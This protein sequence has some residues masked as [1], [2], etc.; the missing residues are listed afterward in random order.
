MGKLQTADFKEVDDRYAKAGG[1]GSEAIPYLRWVAS[2]ITYD[3]LTAAATTDV[4]DL[5]ISLP[6]NSCVHACKANLVTTFDAAVTLSQCAVIAGD[7][8]DPNGLIATLQDLDDNGGTA[9]W[10]TGPAVDELGAY[11]YDST[12]KSLVPKHFT[13]ATDLEA[14]FTLTGDNCADLTQ[15]ALILYFLVSTPGAAAV[16]NKATT[17]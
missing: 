7:A 2:K 5:E 13:T 14:T 8:T 9:G 1:A 3:Q 4:V 11:L 16:V 12:K 6:I 10:Q 17:Q 15:G